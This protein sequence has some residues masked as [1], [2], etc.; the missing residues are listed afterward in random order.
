MSS[1]LGTINKSISSRCVSRSQKFKQIV[2]SV[3]TTQRLIK[4]GIERRHIP[5]EQRKEF[6]RANL[7]E[8]IVRLL[9]LFF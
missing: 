3:E 8:K 6:Q 2:P 9:L 1:P 7:N 5:P 4:L